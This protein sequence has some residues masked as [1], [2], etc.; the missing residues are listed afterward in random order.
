MV[1][2]KDT[3]EPIPENVE[4]YNEVYEVF[5]ACYKGLAADGFEQINAYQ[6]KFC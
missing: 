2:V 4:R 6:N 3:Y 5:K 1:R